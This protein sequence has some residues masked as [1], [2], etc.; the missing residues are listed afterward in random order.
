MAVE[1]Q[2][3]RTTDPVEMLNLVLEEIWGRLCQNY[4]ATAC[5]PEIQTL[6][7]GADLNQPF[8][9]AKTVLVNMLLEVSEAVGR[10]SP[11][12][13]RPA[14][15][16]GLISL[17]DMKSGRNRWILAPEAVQKWQFTLDRLCT[18]IDRSYGVLRAMIYMDAL[19]NDEDVHDPC[20]NPLVTASCRCNPPRSIQLSLEELERG[21]VRC[22]MCLNLFVL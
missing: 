11:W 1:T 2:L 20:Q 12:Y 22:E 19:M 7:D 5:L 9:A 16:Y 14:R 3:D 4:T 17:R 18:V 13:T 8:Q 10:F 21:E 15:A 6:F